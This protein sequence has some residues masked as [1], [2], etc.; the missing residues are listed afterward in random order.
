MRHIM[1]RLGYTD[2]LIAKLTAEFQ[3]NPR[4]AL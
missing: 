4:G 3:R 2:E 1:H